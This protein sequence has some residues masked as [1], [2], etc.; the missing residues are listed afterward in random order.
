MTQ[1]TQQSS[2]PTILR[3]D[4]SAR[5]NGSTTRRLNDFLVARLL[6][7]FP[8]AKVVTRALDTMPLLTEEWV[9]ANFTPV[10][11]RTEA[12][13]REL[14]FSDR[15][16]EELKTADFLVMGV[17]I[18]NFGVPAALKAWVDQVARARVTFRYTANGPEGLLKGKTAF[19]TAASGGVP[20]GG[21]LDFATPYIRQALHFI[22]IDD[23]NLFS[24]RELIQDDQ[25]DAVKTQRQIERALAEH[26]QTSLV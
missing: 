4:A 20:I 10:E 17:P 11:S 8:N 24:V 3:I 25:I 22:G 1:S 14:A 19:V 6:E 13:Q 5:R 16:I 23:V 9:N 2:A 7:R 21:A 12:Q 18:Y 15:L 26:F